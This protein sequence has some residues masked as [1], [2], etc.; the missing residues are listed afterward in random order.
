MGR[1][2][3]ASLG[4]GYSSAIDYSKV[5]ALGGVVLTEMVEPAEA[6]PSGFIRPVKE[7]PWEKLHR[8]VSIGHKVKL[9]LR[10]GDLV[11]IKP[12]TGDPLDSRHRGFA[13]V[14]EECIVCVVD[15]PEADVVVEGSPRDHQPD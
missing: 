4:R 9:E 7:W 10:P 2:R 15:D 8:V 13:T 3:T 1:C 11:V 12:Y 14:R 5:R 6:A